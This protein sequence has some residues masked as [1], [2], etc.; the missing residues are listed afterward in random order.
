MPRTPAQ[1]IAE[2]LVRDHPE[3]FGRDLPAI[4]REVQN[5]I[6]NA[7][8]RHTVQHGPQAG[9]QFFHRNGKAVVVRPNGEGTMVNDPS[10]NWFRTQQIREP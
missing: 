4:E 7:T 1:N 8:H 6:D 3:R 9:S 10:G 2:H 5:V